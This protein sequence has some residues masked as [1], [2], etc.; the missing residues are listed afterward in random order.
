MHFKFQSPTL[1]AFCRA[2]VMN[3][4]CIFIRS[5]YHLRLASVAVPPPYSTINMSIFASDKLVK[6]KGHE[7]CP[8]S[9]SHN[10]DRASSSKIHCIHCTYLWLV[11]CSSIITSVTGPFNS[12][13]SWLS[14]QRQ[15]LW[16][17]KCL[18][19]TILKRQREHFKTAAENRKQ[20]IVSLPN[21]RPKNIAASHQDLN[22][23]SQHAGHPAE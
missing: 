13:A 22:P 7:R 2:V 17:L 15:F 9:T 20:F 4:V 1:C 8:G 18:A 16:D 6:H 19:L 12:S 10:T 3:Q 23:R 11:S 14:P 21:G 5:P